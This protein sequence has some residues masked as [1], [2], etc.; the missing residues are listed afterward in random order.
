MVFDK[1]N[2]LA[3]VWFLCAGSILFRSF[4][5]YDFFVSPRVARVNNMLLDL[6]TM[7]FKTIF[8]G[9]RHISTETLSSYLSNEQQSLVLLD[10]RKKEEVELCI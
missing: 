2:C 5:V 7:S 8:P 4:V 10:V 1:I 9:A 6:L 3:F